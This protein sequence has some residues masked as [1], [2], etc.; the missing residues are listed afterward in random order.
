MIKFVEIMAVS[1]IV[2]SSNAL[3]ADQF[4]RAVVFD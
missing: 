2:R 4:V 3:N 1:T